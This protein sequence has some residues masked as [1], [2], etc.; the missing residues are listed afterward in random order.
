MRHPGGLLEDGYLDAIAQL[1]SLQLG[2]ASIV[3]FD[4]NNPPPDEPVVFRVAGTETCHPGSLTVIEAHI[5]T[6]K[7]AFVS[8]GLAS[9][10]ASAGGD[11]LGWASDGNPHERAVLHFDT[12]QSRGDHHR[13][14]KRALAR[15]GADEA[16]RWLQSYCLTGLSCAEMRQAIEAAIIQAATKF[17]GIHSIWI[18]GFADL[19]KSPNDEEEAF[20]F[21]RWLQELAITHSCPMIGTLHLNPGDTGKSRGHLGSELNRKAEA[22]LRLA[23][24]DAKISTVASKWTRH[25]PIP[26]NKAP[27]FE[28]SDEHGRHVSVLTVGA[29]KQDALLA[30]ARKIVAEARKIVAAVWKGDP[31]AVLKYEALVSEVMRYT[32]QSESDAKRKIGL[33]Q[34]MSLVEKATGRI[35]YVLTAE[36]SKCCE[37][38]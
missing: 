6:G 21:V 22:V 11:C 16:P 20:A 19:V 1:A 26:A 2:D 38:D 23:N 33:I 30:E 3:A 37:T 15:A 14:V 24:D 31:T 29:V 17:D 36:G 9:T 5:K 34:Q 4:A 18:D 32:A 27:R 25:S 28:W 10:M 8:A 12:E 13:L 35:G 7:S